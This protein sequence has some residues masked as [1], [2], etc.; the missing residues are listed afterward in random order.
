[1]APDALAYLSD[2]LGVP[3]TDDAPKYELVCY[4]LLFVVCLLFVIVCCF[5]LFVVVRLSNFFFNYH[6]DLS[7][8][9]NQ[10]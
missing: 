1:M 7:K 4:C 6:N 10:C 9:R 8:G 3:P 2:N 5:L